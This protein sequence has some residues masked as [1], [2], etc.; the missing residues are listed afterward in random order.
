MD[1]HEAILKAQKT[2]R[3]KRAAGTLPNP[4]E[5]FRQHPTPARAIRLK[6]IECCGGSRKQ[7]KMCKDTQCWLYLYRTGRL[8][9]GTKTE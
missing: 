8:D 3:E 5:K 7:P 1:N 9:R 4:E 6:C 2:C